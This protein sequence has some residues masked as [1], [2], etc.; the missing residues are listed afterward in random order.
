MWRARRRQFL[1][2]ASAQKSS[3]RSLQNAPAPYCLKTQAR[4][5]VLVLMSVKDLKRPQADCDVAIARIRSVVR[6]RQRQRVCENRGCSAMGLEC[7]QELGVL[8]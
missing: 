5:S 4:F 3:E 1:G 7:G 8:G 2:Q 6:K